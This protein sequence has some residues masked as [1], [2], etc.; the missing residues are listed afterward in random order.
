MSALEP[1]SPENLSDNEAVTLLFELAA[2]GEE[3]REKL[4]QLDALVYGRLMQAYDGEEPPALRQLGA[5]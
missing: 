5:G 3:A 4:V 2:H 1:I